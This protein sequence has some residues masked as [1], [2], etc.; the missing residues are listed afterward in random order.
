MSTVYLPFATGASGRSPVQT[1][2]S[3]CTR[4]IPLFHNHRIDEEGTLLSDIF[5]IAKLYDFKQLY[6][7]KTKLIHQVPQYN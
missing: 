3:H 7:H 2:K 5:N 4:N 1:M 6:N